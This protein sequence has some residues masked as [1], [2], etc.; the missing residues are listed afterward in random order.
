M[1]RGFRP[2]STATD[3]H[4]DDIGPAAPPH[5]LNQPPAPARYSPVAT[6][7][8]PAYFLAALLTVCVGGPLTAHAQADPHT[9][10][11][12]GD[13]AFAKKDFAAAELHYRRAEE[14]APSYQSAYNLGVVLG[15]LARP[16]EAAALFELARERAADARDRGDASYNAGTARLDEQE[17]QASVAD[18]A[19]ALRARPDDGEARQNLAHALRQLRRQQQ[20][21]QQQQQSQQ[22]QDQQQRG[23]N[24]EEPPEDQGQQPDEQPSEQPQATPSEGEDGEESEDEGEGE[25]APTEDEVPPAE[26]EPRDGGASGQPTLPADE[27]ERLLRL[28]AEQERATAEQRRLGEQ[29]TR[30][31]A[32]DW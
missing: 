26:Q 2:P 15:Y 19:D 6:A 7:P 25:S 32:K 30:Q 24:E 17:L 5:P 4:E 1:S 8:F 12:A 10:L 9:E 31:P 14:A 23:D 29:A 11:R 21:Q 3:P 27:A 16:E 28:A 20:Q 13:E 22:Q 18:Y